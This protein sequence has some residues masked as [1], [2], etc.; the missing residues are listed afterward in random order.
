MVV[1]VDSGAHTVVRVLGGRSRLLWGAGTSVWYKPKAELSS[2]SPVTSGKN[3]LYSWEWSTA[4][5]VAWFISL[6]E[7][8]RR[9]VWQFKAPFPLSHP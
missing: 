8:I 6:L 1:R 2:L 7:K 5:E 3:C 9:G 4:C